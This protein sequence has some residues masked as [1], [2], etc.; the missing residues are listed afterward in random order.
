MLNRT[1]KIII[2]LGILLLTF[3]GLFVPFESEIQKEG[4][5]P[6]IYM[7][8]YF[9]FTPPTELE[10]LEYYAGRDIESNLSPRKSGIYNTYI[11]TSRVWI[12]LVVIIFATTGLTVLFS[13]TEK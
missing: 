9:L 3:S 11:L 12:K 6:K 10:V 4:D 1:Q 2:S 7:G 8:Y 13:G 5:N